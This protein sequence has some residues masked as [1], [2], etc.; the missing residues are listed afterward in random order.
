MVFGTVT[1]VLSPVFRL[2]FHLGGRTV[3]LLFRTGMSRSHAFLSSL[4][5]T[6]GVAKSVTVR[7]DDNVGAESVRLCLAGVL[8][9]SSGGFMIPAWQCRPCDSKE[10]AST[11]EELCGVAD[12]LVV[13]SASVRNLCAY[14]SGKGHACV[15]I[16]RLARH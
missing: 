1:T 8:Q 14:W 15:Q 6:G 9:D 5:R 13:V 12:K 7:E 3:E 4:I 10:G 16:G 2:S 11:G